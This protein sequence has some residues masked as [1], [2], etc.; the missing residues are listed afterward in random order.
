MAGRDNL[1]ERLEQVNPVPDPSRL[2]EDIEP[3]RHFDRTRE[4]RRER[5]MTGIKIHK[6]IPGP[7]GPRLRRGVLIGAAT[8][9]LVIIVGVALALVTGDGTRTVAGESRVL[10]MTFD[11]QQCTY[12]GPS[13][14]S[15]GEIEITYHNQSAERGWAW[16]GRLDE[17]RTIQE[18]ID[19]TADP[20]TQNSPTWTTGLW[21]QLSIFANSSSTPDTVIVEPGLHALLCG[22]WTPSY[23]GYFG[24]PLTVTP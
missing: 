18:I 17:G 9:A 6:L 12:E 16:F 1:L 22:T 11:G 24:S 5:T 14:L 7:Q 19:Y 15:A 2:Y 20:P 10:Q 21:I 3:S 23:A 8:A 13:A 4:H